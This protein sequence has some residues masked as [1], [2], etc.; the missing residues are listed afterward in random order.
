M[1]QLANRW[2]DACLTHP[3][4]RVPIGEQTQ[5]PA[6]LD[7]AAATFGLQIKSSLHWNLAPADHAFFGGAVN[8]PMETGKSSQELLE[9]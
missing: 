9:M 5:I 2:H 3:I 1:S 8:T 4:S 7:Y 6:W